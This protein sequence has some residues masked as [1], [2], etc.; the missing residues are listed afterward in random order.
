MFA[1]KGS[2]AWTTGREPARQFLVAIIL[3]MLQIIS[4]VS[5]IIPKV[6]FWHY[7]SLIFCVNIFDIGTPISQFQMHKIGNIIVKLI[8]LIHFFWVR[9]KAFIFIFCLL[10]LLSAASSS[11]TPS[12]NGT[13]EE[14][15]GHRVAKSKFWNLSNLLFISLS[16]KA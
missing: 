3:S 12:N 14:S 10:I 6:P 8:I 13:T 9:M 2:M 7:S 1:T 4:N 5:P 15:A 16:D 11:E